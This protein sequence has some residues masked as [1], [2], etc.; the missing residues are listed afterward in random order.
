MNSRKLTTSMNYILVQ[1]SEPS[2]NSKFL[3]IKARVKI[4]N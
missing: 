3:I 1:T 2:A 4:E